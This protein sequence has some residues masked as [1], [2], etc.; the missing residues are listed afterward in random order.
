[1]KLRIGWSSGVAL[2]GLKQPVDLGDGDHASVVEPD[3]TSANPFADRGFGHAEHLRGL[4]LI[5]V[6]RARMLRGEDFNG[7]DGDFE[8]VHFLSFQNP[9]SLACAF[10]HFSRSAF[11]SFLACSCRAH[12]R[13]AFAEPGQNCRPADAVFPRLTVD[14]HAVAVSAVRPVQFEDVDLVAEIPIFDDDAAA[15]VG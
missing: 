4:L 2:R 8:V 14:G 5:D 3:S 6:C 1:M 11:M 7:L 12:P 9:W 15:Q 10:V 13:H